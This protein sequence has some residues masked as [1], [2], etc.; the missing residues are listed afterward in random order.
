MTLTKG[1]KIGEKDE[2][3]SIIFQRGKEKKRKTAGEKAM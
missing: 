1:E 3:N 2:Y